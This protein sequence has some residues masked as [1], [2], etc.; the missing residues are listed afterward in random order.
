[1][2]ISIMKRLFLAALK[3]DKDRLLN[4]LMGY[5]CVE[6]SS[7]GLGLNGTEMTE[8]L[9][10][11]EKVPFTLENNLKKLKSTIESLER[12]DK[13][14]RPL[15]PRLRPVTKAEVQAQL[16]KAMHISDRVTER[17]NRLNALR[18]ERH[19][20]L[21]N[22][23]SLKPYGQL[24]V[25]LAGMSTAKTVLITGTIPVS[26]PEEMLDEAIIAADAELVISVLDSDKEVHHIFGIYPKDREE[27]SLSLLKSFG[28]QKVVFKDVQSG[29][30]KENMDKMKA[31][32]D[33]IDLEIKAVEESLTE[34]VAELP[35]IK[36]A[37]DGLSLEMQK[38]K[39]FEKLLC[40][41]Q[42]F[43]AECWV[44]AESAEQVEK[45]LSEYDCNYEI[46]DPQEGE[47]PPVLLKNS[48]IVAPFSTV[49]EL[50]SLP[51]YGSVDPNPFIT[52]FFFIFFGMMLGDA[53]FGAILTIGCFGVVFGLKPSGEFLKKL[54]T[55]I[56]ICGISTMIWGILTGSYF[57]DIIAVAGKTFFGAEIGNL[58]ILFS[59]M[60]E[61]M[62]MLVICLVIGLVHI[63]IGMGLQAYLLIKRGRIW[64]AVADVGFWY[65][66]II[67]L[68]VWGFA[69]KP[70]LYMTIAGAAGLILTQG[71]E[72][73]NPVM[74]LLSGIMSLYGITGYLADVLSYS[75]ILAL[76]LSSGVM[77]S[78]F[79]TIGTLL[80][81]SVFG[82]LLF[83]V[84]FVIGGVFNLALSSLGS[85][86]HSLRL[87]YVEFFGKF[88][89]SG[90]RAFEP[91]RRE[92]RYIQIIDREAI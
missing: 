86:V 61:P 64:A 72:K 76:G 88:Y 90:G 10:P 53:A 33:E 3:K 8:L 74:K 25:D 48:K 29:T 17:V 5:S 50:Y 68:L 63:F 39:K 84:V 82:V 44:P 9:S 69:G 11:G 75:R 46:R 81:K 2:A 6:V 4:E 42:V 22:I 70:G 40:S 37:Y 18:G 91:F 65:L 52:V 34:T 30:A 13:S 26:W 67:G 24:D 58:S 87:N 19:R 1:M 54:L 79:N 89:E 31:R 32:L 15:F 28:Y 47:E 56:G 38:D 85:F 23:E 35:G 36:A 66:F 73:K 16:E 57:G 77:A 51:A 45:L 49:T 20:L 12:Y 55:M 78:V 41:D 14:K 83:I 60:D 7:P 71:R 43:Y 27:E 21:G 62:T 92:T 80:G 59:P